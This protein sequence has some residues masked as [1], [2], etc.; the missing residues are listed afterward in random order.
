VLVAATAVEELP[1]TSS[2]DEVGVIDAI[3]ESTPPDSEGTDAAPVAAAADLGVDA[4]MVSFTT[5]EFA[6]AEPAKEVAASIN[7]ESASVATSVDGQAVERVEQPQ[8]VPH[9]VDNA[10]DLDLTDAFT[11]LEL[12]EPPPPTLDQVPTHRLNVHRDDDS[13][14][15]LVQHGTTVTPD[16]P[17]DVLSGPIGP[18]PE[19]ARP[20][21]VSPVSDATAHL[22][23][24]RAAV[25]ESEPPERPRR[26]TQPMALQ[27]R[28]VQVRR[29]SRDVPVVLPSPARGS[30]A[31]ADFAEP[32]A[33]A[34]PRNSLRV[35]AVSNT[36][37]AE[38]SGAS[39]PVLLDHPR[40]RASGGARVWLIV[41]GG[42]AS[43]AAAIGWYLA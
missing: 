3:P 26:V 18:L 4:E 28:G 15:F 14:G 2:D 25:D 38:K 41:G 37:L 9:A 12:V 27:T 17:F 42:L 32:D 8:D 31:I 30:V 11:S 29:P 5:S 23:G 16:E 13:L 10:N 34:A 36:P 33:A 43:L 40:V 24:N 1:A 7:V 6:I 20:A 22:S 35:P 19:L 21:A 39:R